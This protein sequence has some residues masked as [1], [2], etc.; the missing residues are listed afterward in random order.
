[1]SPEQRTGGRL[2]GRSDLFSIGVVLYEAATGRLPAGAFAPPSR[3]NPAFSVAF[4]RVV[5]RLLQPEPA[6]RYASAEEAGRAIAAALAPAWRARRAAALALGGLAATMA[7]ATPLMLRSL[8][9]PGPA[10]RPSRPSGTPA[11][12]RPASAAQQAAPAQQAEP[13]QDT[14]P[15]PRIDPPPPPLDL[16]GTLGTVS[17]SNGRQATSK[18]KPTGNP[19][20]NPTRNP[21]GNPTR[22]PTRKKGRS[23]G[24]MAPA[25]MGLKSAFEKD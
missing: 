9:R 8:T 6:D 21:T 13:A 24:K 16:D 10:D 15:R 14:D 2:D 17:K 22:N 4:D 19:A 11:I 25:S 3:L 12:T 23:V 5:E 7:V 18:L 1:M 20:G